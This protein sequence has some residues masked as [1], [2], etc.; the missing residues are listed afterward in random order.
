MH[1]A[2]VLAA[3][4][5][6]SKTAWYVA[7]GALAVW[8]VIVAAIGITQPEFPGKGAGRNV[9]MAISILLVAAAMAMAV[10]SS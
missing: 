2:L 7:G 8:A 4:A 5:E 10:V 3:A 9:V 1:A 6:K